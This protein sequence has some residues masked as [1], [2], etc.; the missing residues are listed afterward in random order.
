METKDQ[1]AAE[2]KLPLEKKASAPNNTPPEKKS[3]WRRAV[4]FCFIFVLRTF[5]LVSMISILAGAFGWFIFLRAFNAQR[6]S[7]FITEEIQN[8]LGRPVMISSLD[9][10]FINTLELK[11][12]S[13]IDTKGEPGKTLM[14]ADSVTLKFKLAPLLDKQLEIEEITFNAPRFNIVRL[15]EGG[16]NIPQIT[17]SEKKSVYTSGTGDKFAVTLNNWAIRDGV[18]SYKDFRT[19]DTHALYGLNLH[20]EKLHFNELS[21][22]TMNMIVRN[23][24]GENISDLEIEGAGQVNFADFDWTSFALRSVKARAYLFSKPLE[25]TFDLDNLRTPYFKIDAKVPAFASKDLSLFHLENVDFSVPKSELS[26]QGRWLNNYQQIKLTQ[27]TVTADDVKVTASGTFNLTDPYQV[28]LKASTNTFL[29]TGKEKFLPFLK[30]YKI[31]GKGSLSAHITRTDGKYRLPLFTVNVQQADG[32]VYTFPLKDVTGE[33]QAKDN[34]SDLYLHAT[35][36]QVTVARSVFD[37]LDISASW[38]KGNLY[39]NIASCTLNEVPFKMNLTVEKLKNKNRNI[40]TNMHWKHLD[41]MAFIGTVQDFVDV[42][43]PLV[44]A[45]PADPEV[46]GELAWLRNFRDRLPNFMPNLAGTL[47]A[48]TF[49]SDILSGNAFNA[50]L[51]LTGL[52]AGAQEL[53]GVLK[54]Q[55]KG[56]VIHQM[57][58]WAE[59]QEALNVTFQPF[60][61]MNRMERAGSF[62]VGKV[63][64]DVAF[65]DLAA[66]V[67]LENGH[68]NISNAYTVGPTISAAVSGWTDWV[69]ETFDLTIWTMFN[70]TSRHGALA[71]N[72]TDESGS[73]ALA[74]RVYQSMTKPKLDMLRAK[75][76]GQTIQAAQEK[77]VETDF[78]TAQDFVKGEFHAKK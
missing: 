62:K 52:K 55:L 47:S 14:S 29:I 20:F 36:G 38:R 46:T 32:E 39:A 75:K 70:N 44:H 31:Q 49:A 45:G 11:G 61:I 22:F 67:T 63:L 66:S 3:V 57:E 59:E 34:F 8:R 43:S 33:F 42:I 13:V 35:D 17:P 23:Q 50:E 27:G 19:G 1:P 78:H 64:K 72:L 73:P 41:P 68:M 24:W 58:K 65:D 9:L 21:R 48:D 18:I 15:A 60:I 26:A 7:D 69:K 16:Y 71:E 76:A 5:L 28:D 25:I 56:G 74:F 53:S 54:A 77:G 6:I 2:T 10:A 30:P 4:K 51:D 37:K 12:F 40:R